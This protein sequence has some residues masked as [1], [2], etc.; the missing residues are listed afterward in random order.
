MRL[1]FHQ[2]LAIGNDQHEHYTRWTYFV[3]TSYSTNLQENT[4]SYPRMCVTHIRSTRQGIGIS[5]TGFRQGVQFW[6]LSLVL[7]VVRTFTANPM[8]E[9]GCIIFSQANN[10]QSMT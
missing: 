9:L 7:P 3:G 1:Y 2:W 8:Y 4:I 10:A 6:F 5:T